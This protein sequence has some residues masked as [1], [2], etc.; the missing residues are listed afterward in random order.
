MSFD[1][2]ALVTYGG[3]QFYVLKS[4]GS[5]IALLAR[6]CVDG[7]GAQQ[8]TTATLATASTYRGTVE[9]DYNDYNCDA[10]SI[11]QAYAKKIGAS[12]GG[13]PTLKEIRELARYNSSVT[14]S[15]TSSYWL[16]TTATFKYNNQDYA[17]S[18]YMQY[19]QICSPNYSYFTKALFVRPVINVKKSSVTL[20]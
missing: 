16:G 4:F 9:D 12:W 15:I 14:T 1:L 20:K 19:G 3:E 7:A 10:V 2:G 13:L 6:Y 5:N 11:A 18:Y 8:S 17:G